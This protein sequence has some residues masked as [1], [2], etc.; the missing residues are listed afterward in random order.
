L[1]FRPPPVLLKRPSP[2]PT[3]YIKRYALSGRNSRTYFSTLGIGTP[4]PGPS[5]Q[6]LAI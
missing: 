6:Y 1:R 5:L 3:L 2:I 4:Q